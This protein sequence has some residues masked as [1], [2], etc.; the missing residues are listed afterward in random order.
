MEQVPVHEGVRRI[1]F[2]DLLARQERGELSQREAAEMP[3]ISE[4][5]FRQF[6]T[7]SGHPRRQGPCRRPP[8]C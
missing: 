2:E 1:G 6:L 3:G 4:R 7:R 8:D 5:T